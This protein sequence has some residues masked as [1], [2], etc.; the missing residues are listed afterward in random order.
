MDW[1]RVP[2]GVHFEGASGRFDHTPLTDAA[3][4]TIARGT[5]LPGL[6]L[7]DAVDEGLDAALHAVRAHGACPVLIVGNSPPHPPD[8][9]HHP[10]SELW[11]KLQY[12]ALRASGEFPKRLAELREKG[13]VVG[14][15]F[16]TGHDAK[17]WPGRFMEIQSHVH[18]AYQRVMPVIK[19]LAEPGDVAAQVV[20]L[21]SLLR[22]SVSGVGL[23]V[24]DA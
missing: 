20:N 5:Y 21:V 16:L 17:T 10:F 8:D 7:W 23:K 15:V 19:A 3:H 4:S 13:C 1:V 9:P 14:M 11:Q 18:D 12:S 22:R 24:E 6:D 2:K